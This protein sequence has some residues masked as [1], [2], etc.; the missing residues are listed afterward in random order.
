MLWRQICLLHGRFKVTC[1]YG[2][3]GNWAKGSHSGIDLVG[4]SSKVV[5][6]TS[7]GTVSRTGFDKSYGNFVV[8]KATDG[9]YHWF[10]HL[11]SISVSTGQKVTR[12][13]KVGIMGST[14]NSTGPHTHYEIRTP[15]NK[16]GKDINPAEYMGI[17]NKVGTYHSAD[18]PVKAAPAPQPQPVPQP[19]IEYYP[20]C[21]KSTLS[22]VDGL[23]AIGVDSSKANRKKIAAKNGISNYSGSAE[24]NTALLK[25]LK[26]GKLIK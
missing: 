23:K 22:I 12:V 10:C 2:R 6:A 20:A 17:P 4:L 21:P 9:Y 18:Y 1:E 25:K 5:Y 26:A 7:D 24:Q 15:E 16:Y 19:V 8:V 3:K 13:S 14:G 11:A